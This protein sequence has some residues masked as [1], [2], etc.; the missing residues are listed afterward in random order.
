MSNTHPIIELAK[1]LR[2]AARNGS[3]LHLEPCQVAIL[4]GENI[5]GAICAL[6]AEEFRRACAAAATNDNSVGIIGFGSDPTMASG[7]SAGSDA[8]NVDAVSRGAR[9]RLTEAM[10]ELQLHKKQSTH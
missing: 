5:Y 10:S 3:R 8:I 2:R 1:R 9:L 6:E 4:M 7:A